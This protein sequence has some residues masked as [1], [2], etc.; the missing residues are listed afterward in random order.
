MM[1]AVA[2][3]IRDKVLALIPKEREVASGS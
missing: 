3:T 1:C 2:S